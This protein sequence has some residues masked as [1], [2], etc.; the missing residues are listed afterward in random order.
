MVVVVINTR[1]QS[2]G[3]VEVVGGGGVFEGDG[4]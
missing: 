2:S 1:G 3:G 4:R